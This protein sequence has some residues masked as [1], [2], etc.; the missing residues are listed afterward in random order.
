[1]NDGDDATN[2]ALDGFRSAAYVLRDTSTGVWV[3]QTE[4]SAYFVDLDHRDFVRLPGFGSGRAS[5]EAALLVLAR[6]ASDWRLQQLVKLRECAVGRRM[7]LVYRQ[8]GGSPAPLRST[9]V[10]A[11]APLPPSASEVRRND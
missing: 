1:M 3:V 10:E 7:R 2:F 6:N 11:I 8:P 4:T 5:G 9:I